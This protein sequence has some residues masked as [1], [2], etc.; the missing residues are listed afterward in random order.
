MRHQ[1]R[2]AEQLEGL[3]H[4][5][6]RAALQW[7]G[8]VEARRDSLARALQTALSPARLDLLASRVDALAANMA[9]AMPR[10][11]TAQKQRLDAAHQRLQTAEQEML[12]CSGRELD[13]LEFALSAA[14]P[15]APLKRGYALVRGADGGLLRSVAA[16]P[17]GSAI[18][19]RLADGSLA[20]VV[21][22]VQPD[23]ERPAASEAAQVAQKQG[24]KS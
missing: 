2:L 18:S 15:L 8:S 12:A 16:A 11:L 24:R 10:L 14:N 7:V 13:K 23:A 20:A 6:H 1:A 9:S 17:V 5:L 3:H 4:R 22:Q 21:S 19:V